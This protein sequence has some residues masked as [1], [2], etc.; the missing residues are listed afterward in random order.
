MSDHNIDPE[1]GSQLEIGHI[2]GPTVIFIR[3][4]KSLCSHENLLV[5][6]K[7]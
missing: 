5:L 3:P 2:W 1:I 7:G 6:L 4:Y